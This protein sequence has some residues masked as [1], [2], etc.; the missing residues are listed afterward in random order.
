MVEPCK[1]DIFA[2]KKRIVAIRGE[3]QQLVQN[4]NNRRDTRSSLISNGT[5]CFQI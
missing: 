4:D 3:V 1:T 5:V 2:E